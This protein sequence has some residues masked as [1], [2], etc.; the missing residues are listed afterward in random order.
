[1]APAVDDLGDDEIEVSPTKALFVDMLTKD[2][3]VN[4]AVIDLIDNSIDG[5]RRLRT[6]SNFH[7][8]EIVI[9]LNAERFSIKDNCGGIGIEL[10]RR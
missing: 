1:M 4:R 9:N 8:L 6:D 7:G 2:I 10:A 5:A 3:S